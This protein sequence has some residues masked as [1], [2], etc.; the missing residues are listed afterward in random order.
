MLFRFRHL[1]V[2]F[3]AL[4]LTFACASFTGAQND[5]GFGDAAVDPIKLFDK[6]QDAH[7]K[8]NLELAL[9]FYEEAI[10]VRP[11]FPEAEYQRAVALVALSRLPEAEKSFRR[12]IELR[13]EWALPQA[14]LGA[15][16]LRLKRLDEAQA[17]LERAL[18]L[19]ARNPVALLALTDLYLRRKAPPAAMQQLLGQL[20]QATASDDAGGALWSARGSIEYALGEKRAALT[21]FDR[22]LNLNPVDLAARIERAELRAEAGDFE[23]ALEDAGAALRAAPRSVNASL[24]LA[25]IQ[26]QAGKKD[27]ARR[28]LEALDE[29]SKQ[30]PEVI[31]LRNAMLASEA[32]DDAESCAALQKLLETDARNAS[33]LAR[34]GSCYRVSDP[35]RSIDYYR[36]AS[37]L[38]PRSL[39]YA[40]GYTAALV[41][42][43]RFAEASII[44]RRILSV[45]PDNYTAHANLATALYELKRYPEALVEY[46]WLLASKPDLTVAYFFIGTVHDY[47]GQYPEA[48][49][50]YE[51]FL[52]RANPKDNQLEIDKINLRLPSLRRQIARGEGAKRKKKE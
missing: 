46:N 17:S 38:E 26:A 20:Q 47:L 9:E 42:A 3:L 1:A 39:A 28:T 24:T 23:R 33:L 16:L 10:K 27:E 36:R 7:Q 44:A 11:E 12:A 37:D 51:T 18:K 45:A 35:A 48:L 15:L 40:T 30:L 13:A 52:A 49:A 22:A 50:A 6:G 41:Q 14:A 25:R 32:G 34:L 19:D 4:S 43:R 29:A 8:G 5:D 2:I 31:A 21:S